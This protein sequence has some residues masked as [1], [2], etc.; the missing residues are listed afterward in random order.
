MARSS[1]IPYDGTTYSENQ[2]NITLKTSVRN[3]DGTYYFSG[4]QLLPWLSVN[5]SVQ[6]GKLNIVSDD[7]TLWELIEE[8]DPDGYAFDFVKCCEELGENSKWVKAWAGMQ[9]FGIDSILGWLPSLGGNSKEEHYYYDIFEDMLQ[10][11][12]CTESS[13][14]ELM[15]DIEKCNQWMEWI[16][17]LGMEEEL[18]DELRAMGAIFKGIGSEPNQFGAELGF[19][20][21]SI[22]QDN[23][24]KLNAL[25]YMVLHGTGFPQSMDAAAQTII[26]EYED[27]ILGIL[28]KTI[29]ALTDYLKGLMGDLSDNLAFKMVLKA[30]DFPESVSSE[31]SEEIRR[32]DFY[33]TIA[34]GSAAAYKEER[35]ILSDAA[36]SSMGIQNTRSMAYMYLYATEQNWRAMYDYAMHLGKYEFAKEYALRADEAEEM[37]AQVLASAYAQLNDSPKYGDG[38]AQRKQ[39]YTDQLKEMFAQL[40]FRTEFINI[41]DLVTIN[42][43]VCTCNWEKEERVFEIPQINL[44]SPQI[45]TINK[46]IMDDYSELIHDCDRVGPDTYSTYYSVT[47][48]YAMKGDILSVFIEEWIAYSDVSN[49]RIYNISLTQRALVDDMTVIAEAGMSEAEYQTHVK[50]A[51]CSQFWYFCNFLSNSDRDY[52][53]DEWFMFDAMLQDTIRADNVEAA[54]PFLGENG[55]LWVLGNVYIPAGGGEILLTVNLNDYEMPPNYAESLDFEKPEE[56]MRIELSWNGK[57]SSGY[58]LQLDADISGTLDDGSWIQI[59]DGLTYNEQ[60]QPAAYCDYDWF[61]GFI[62]YHLYQLDGTFDFEVCVREDIAD[63]IGAICESGAKAVVTYPDGRSFTYTLDQGVYQSYTGHWFWAPFSIDHGTLVGYDAS[64]MHSAA[65]NG[66]WCGDQRPPCGLKTAG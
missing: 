12:T 41:E 6:E 46:Q 36:V 11:Q 54:I 58:P 17:I 30:I 59:G 16:E 42:K 64:W 52:S 32:V 1:L 4:T 38:E 57:D 18:P 56:L 15:D 33:D 25:K 3:V 26:V 51:L 7:I 40:D 24:V 34:K 5:C 9:G 48:D 61:E 10:D 60:E 45:D 14:D 8:F 53:L 63:Y 44:D 37:A 39:A 35:D 28:G 66:R 2:K 19:Y 55:D 21:T 65:A 62:V 49:Y 29:D 13:L 47:C 31:L 27:Y 50:Q 20:L 43:I 22:E 23:Q